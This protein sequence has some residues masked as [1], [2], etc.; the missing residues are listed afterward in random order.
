MEMPREIT[1][2]EH[3]KVSFRFYGTA[4]NYEFFLAKIL[5]TM[6]EKGIINALKVANIVRIKKNRHSA[7]DVIDIIHHPKDWMINEVRQLPENELEKIETKQD[8]IR[9]ASDVAGMN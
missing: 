8:K 1:I 4:K 7:F 5:L 6:E 2:K 9:Q 3:E